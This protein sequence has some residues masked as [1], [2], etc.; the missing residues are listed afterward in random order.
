M[1]EMLLSGGK[2]AG[3]YFPD[4][5][6]GVKKLQAGNKSYGY[7]GEV[8]EDDMMVNAE[9]ARLLNL[10]SAQNRTVG[11]ITNTWFKFVINE[12]FLFFPKIPL[13][14]DIPIAD[15]YALKAVFDA[16]ET[17]KPT[18]ILDSG[19]PMYTQN[20][21]VANGKD[22]FKLRLMDAVPS[23]FQANGNFKPI[24]TSEVAM[25][26][27]AL[28][29]S[30]TNAVWYPDTL[31]IAKYTPVQMYLPVGVNVSQQGWVKE[32]HITALAY[33]YV[34]DVYSASAG[35]YSNPTFHWR[36][37][38]ELVPKSAIAALV[39][40]PE[41]LSISNKDLPTQ[42][43]LSGMAR[44]DLFPLTSFTNI[45]E[46][47]PV[48][49]SGA[50]NTGFQLQPYQAYSAAYDAGIYPIITALQSDDIYKLYDTVGLVPQREGFNL[51]TVVATDDSVFTLYDASGYPSNIYNGNIAL[52]TDDV[53]YSLYDVY[54]RSP[55]N[56]YLTAA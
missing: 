22:L 16:D 55:T 34:F 51:P 1:L 38:L 27:M 36:P 15:L 50:G 39:I 54:G 42:V 48:A 31:G 14:G 28:Y 21:F 40:E 4:S 52:P 9:F 41:A 11:V 29:K 37:V 20:R 3:Q 25:L 56:G 10:T 32:T 43:T 49:M 45:V 5:G 17:Y 47:R 19:K 44:P 6:P 12:K 30:N 13:A 7:F 2:S 35:N 23:A 46:T 18:T 24:V 33:P 8:S 26:L 53:A